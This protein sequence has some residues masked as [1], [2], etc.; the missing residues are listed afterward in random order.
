MNKLLLTIAVFATAFLLNN[1]E[2]NAQRFGI[3]VQFNQPQQIYRGHY[4]RNLNSYSKSYGYRPYG[5][6]YSR[7]YGYG[8]SYGYRPYGYGYSRPYSYGY[9]YSKP[10]GYR[11]K[12]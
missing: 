7:P 9:R 1:N 5:Y 12:R 11:Y 6:G 3:Q 4:G 8:Y 2:A 10:Y